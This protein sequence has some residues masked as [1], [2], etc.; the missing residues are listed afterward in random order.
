MYYVWLTQVQHKFRVNEIEVVISLKRENQIWEIMYLKIL[1][2]M[3]Q[4]LR[5]IYEE[6]KVWHNASKKQWGFTYHQLPTFFTFTLSKLIWYVRDATWYVME[7]T[8]VTYVTW[9]AC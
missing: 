9:I 5:S 8:E 1:F 4:A 7:V 6:L 3:S 2:Q